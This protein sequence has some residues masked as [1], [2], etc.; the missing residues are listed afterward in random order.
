MLNPL[1]VVP[2]NKVGHRPHTAD[3]QRRSSIGCDGRTLNSLLSFGSKSSSKQATP[4]HGLATKLY[5]PKPY[6]LP[7]YNHQVSSKNTNKATA[8]SYSKSMSSF[9]SPSMSSSVTPGL[10]YTP[11][12]KSKQVNLATIH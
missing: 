5:Q 7:Q 3:Q 8:S 9:C 4:S 6:A 2:L 12:N 1:V 11:R 10:R